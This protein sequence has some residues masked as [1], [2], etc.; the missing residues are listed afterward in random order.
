MP[1]A[2]RWLRVLCCAALALGWPAASPARGDILI[3]HHG[4]RFPNVITAA[5][6]AIRISD[7]TPLIPGKETI[8]KGYRRAD[9]T[10]F[11][12][13]EIEGRIF[14]IEFDDDGKPPFEYSIMDTDGDGKFETKIPHTKDNKDRAYV[15]QWM[16]DHYYSRHPELKK[17]TARVQVPGPGL[18][19]TEPPPEGAGVAKEPR[20]PSPEALEQPAP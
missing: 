9:G 7:R 11:Q 6:E 14:G 18:T 5:K 16:V 2:A 17:P 20:P 1:R 10:H 3:N 13:Y 8:T 4:W 19:R 15:P 12:T